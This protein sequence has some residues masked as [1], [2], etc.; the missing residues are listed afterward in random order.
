MKGSMLFICE[1]K[2]LV[3]FVTVRHSYPCLIFFNTSRFGV[4]D[5]CSMDNRK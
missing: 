1:F 3:G 4:H 5:P 2:V